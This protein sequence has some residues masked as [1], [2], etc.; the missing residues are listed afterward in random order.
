MNKNLGII[1]QEKA[2]KLAQMDAAENQRAQAI[3][4]QQDTLAGCTWANSKEQILIA[5]KEHQLGKPMH[6]LDMEN[7]IRK[8]PGGNNYIF[9]DFKDHP[10]VA[11]RD[12]PFKACYYKSPSNSQ[13]LMVSPYGKVIL[14]EWGGYGG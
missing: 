8:L 4:Y 14:P 3:Q 12:R 5:N 7:I 9:F 6:F 11:L 1:D 13:P 2:L 10:I